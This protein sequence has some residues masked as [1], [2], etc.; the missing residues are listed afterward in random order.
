M[1]ALSD[2]SSFFTRVI[3]SGTFACEL[4]V[5]QKQH[6]KS[7]TGMKNLFISDSSAAD[8]NTESISWKSQRFIGRSNATRDALVNCQINFIVRHACDALKSLQIAFE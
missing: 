4:K 5:K 8:P 2:M 7:V 3:D 1:I 6:K